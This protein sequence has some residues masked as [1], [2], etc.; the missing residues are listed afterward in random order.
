[1]S[2]STKNNQEFLIEVLKLSVDFN[3]QVMSILSVEL[4]G[5]QSGK[6]RT[7]QKKQMENLQL[8]GSAYSRNLGILYDNRDKELRGE[9]VDSSVDDETKK[10]VRTTIAFLDEKMKTDPNRELA[11]ASNFLELMLRNDE[12]PAEKKEA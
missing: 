2:Q 8:L 12:V 11:D 6:N 3:S 7:H 1:M 10:A 5:D 4:A 9:E